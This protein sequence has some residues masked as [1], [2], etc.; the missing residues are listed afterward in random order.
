MQGIKYRP[1]NV[2]RNGFT[3]IELTAVTG[4]L[5]L[6]VALLLPAVQQSREAAR[7]TQCRNNLKQLA[8]ALH[9][10]HDV[11]GLFPA[12][13]IGPGVPSDG[14][15][16][17]R[18]SAHVGLLPFVD[19]APLYNQIF[20]TKPVKVGSVTGTDS[21]IWNRSLP[22]FVCPSDPLPQ[23]S[24]GE[25]QAGNN[26]VYNVGDQAVDDGTD[27]TAKTITVVQVRGVFGANSCVSIRKITDGT[28]NTVMT[29]EAVRPAT[30]RS[31]G[32][33]SPHVAKVPADVWTGFDR[34]KKEFDGD[35][36][37]LKESP[38]GYRWADGAGFYNGFSMILPP[39]SPSAFTVKEPTTWSPGIFSVSSRHTGGSNIGMCDGSVR[40]VSENIDAGNN[41]AALPTVESDDSESPYG[42][43]GALGTKAGGEVID[44]F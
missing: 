39:N 34:S 29:A 30:H 33:K 6:L 35:G 37:P 1:V 13:R 38:F 22:L 5:M 9:N 3:G 11:F 36:L 4:V 25:V 2:P 26:Y 27:A 14:S 18:L 43:W 19:Q 21:K 20:S 23:S 41:K 12:R 8:L 44:E 28:S 17:N 15:F 7:R 16:Q 10:Y 31:P 32:M 40:F 24:L 42:V